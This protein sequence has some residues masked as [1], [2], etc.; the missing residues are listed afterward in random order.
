MR[1]KRVMA[2]LYGSG[3]KIHLVSICWSLDAG[4]LMLVTRHTDGEHLI[5]DAGAGH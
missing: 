2:S 5:T 3:A 4:D 1:Q